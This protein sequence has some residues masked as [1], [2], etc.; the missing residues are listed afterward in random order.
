MGCGASGKPYSAPIAA[1]IGE[2]IEPANLPQSKERSPGV[3]RKP[4]K[5]RRLDTTGDGNVDTILKDTTKDGRYDT[6]LVRDEEGRMVALKDTNDDGK[7]DRIEYDTD[8]GGTV[9]FASAT[10]KPGVPAAVYADSAGSGKPNR[11]EQDTNRDGVL[12]ILKIDTTG[13]GNFDYTIIVVP[14]PMEET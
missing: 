2:Q 14:P 4:S 11:I 7:V 10:C 6:K 13:D 1:R 8:G 3:P 5:E 9:A 12:N